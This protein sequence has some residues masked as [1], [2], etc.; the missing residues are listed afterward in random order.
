MDY[1]QRRI[2]IAFIQPAYA[3]YRRPFFEKFSSNYD[4]KFY[5]MH[6]C[7]AHLEDNVH[8][9]LDAVELDKR[10]CA[11]NPAREHLP[12]SIICSCREGINLLL[13]LIVNK[14][15]VIVTS[16]SVSPQTVISVLVSKIKRTPCVLWNEQWF[17]PR[18]RSLLFSLIDAVRHHVLANVAV[19]VVEGTP[20]KNFIKN[21]GIPERIFQSNHC[22]LDYSTLPSKNL[23]KDLHIENKIVILYMGRIIKRKGLH[24]LIKAFSAIEQQRN[25]CVLL[26]C[27][28]GDFFPACKKI[29]YELGIQNILFLGSIPENKIASCYK[30]ADVFV[31]PA[32]KDSTDRVVT[33]G[34]GLVI[35]E[36]IGMGIP[37]ITTNVVGAAMDLVKNDFNGYIVE[38]GKADDLYMA[39]AVGNDI[40]FAARPIV[41]GKRGMYMTSPLLLM[42]DL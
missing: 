41:L 23:K 37:I 12:F 21:R 40:I 27:G 7:P 9:F 25:D 28:N 22:S 24:V 3:K 31:L 4:T 42:K 20:Q 10:T 35:N 15:D 38:N 6:T 17:E 2:R 14:F 26:V 13:S 39:S 8:E 5:F 11:V 30:T 16:I 29:A 18:R 19:V 1:K 32:C 36:A 34:W 33:E